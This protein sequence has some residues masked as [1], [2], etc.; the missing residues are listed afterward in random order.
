MI[1]VVGATGVLGGAVARRLLE[2]GEDVHAL[3]GDSTAAQ[4]LADAGAQLVR[5]DL[6]DPESLRA[7]ADGVETVVTTANSAMRGGEDTVDTV[8]RAG[9]AALVDAAASAGVRRFVFVS[10]LGADPASPVPFMQ[11]K[12]ETEQRVRDSGMSWTVVEPNAFMDVWVPA[13]LV[14][15]AL[16][17]QPVHLVGESRRRHSFIAMADV[18][19]YVAAAVDH[20]AVTNRTLVLGG[21]EPVTWWDIV[22]EAGRALGRDIAVRAVTPGDPVPGL[23]PDMSAII[24]SMETYD[25]PVDMEE[26]ARILGV[27]PT[28]VR[29]FVDRF[30]AIARG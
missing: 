16:A 17:G 2:Q 22:H 26:T 4:P 18:A 28:P 7:A 9:N 1:L 21:P 11:A 12:G 24:T 27:T 20:E 15:P 10:A 8:E 25:S 23:S 29:D 3:V 14:G 19:A 30:V 6:K 5:G 13:V